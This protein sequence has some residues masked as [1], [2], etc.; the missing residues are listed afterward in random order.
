MPTEDKTNL[1]PRIASGFGGGIGLCG[2]VCGSLAGSI[3]AV[4]VKYGSN[5]SGEGNNV[6]AY[7]KSWKLFKQFEK[8]HGSVICR[9]LIKYDLS[10]PEELAKA[11]QEG[12]FEKCCVKFVGSA[13]ENFLEMEQEQV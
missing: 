2:S 11:R 9:E 5:E 8:Q 7:T 6:K 3:M 13:V 4:G 12:V 10:N 1:I